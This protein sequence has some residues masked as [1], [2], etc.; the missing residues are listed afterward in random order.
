M[1]SKGV[2]HCALVHAGGNIKSLLY[3]YQS[4]HYIMVPSSPVVDLLSQ[5]KI[6][7]CCKGKGPIFCAKF[8]I[9][10][11]QLSRSTPPAFAETWSSVLHVNTM[12]AGHQYQGGGVLQ[13]GGRI[14]KIFNF[15]QWP[16][17]PSTAWRGSTGQGA[18]IYHWIYCLGWN[19]L[20]VALEPLPPTS[21]N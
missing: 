4:V 20:M 21:T 7:F 11:R 15:L 9:G 16:R 12:S 2:V 17:W 3:R 1:L 5:R 8:Q 18:I 13:G 14:I 6:K 19:L 10:L